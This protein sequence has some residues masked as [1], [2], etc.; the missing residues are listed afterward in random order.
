MS[1][2]RRL[3]RRPPLPVTTIRARLTLVYAAISVLT[4]AGSLAL[5]YLLLRE[6]VASKSRLTVE[7]PDVG[8]LPAGVR[9]IRVTRPEDLA[10]AREADL[11]ELLWLLTSGAVVL[12]AVA[13]LTGWFMAGR[14]LRPVQRITQA[15]RSLSSED[16][17]GRL[18][19]G[20][21]QDEL[22]ELART[23]DGFLDRLQVAVES[24]KRFVAKASHELRTPLAIQR[25]VL[26]VALADPSPEEVARARSDLLE[27]N[28]RSEQLIDA[29]LLLARGEER[30]L[31]TEQVRLDGLVEEVVQEES[32]LAAE[33]GVRLDTRLVPASVRGDRV[34]LRHLV[35]N[36]VRNALAHNHQGGWAMVEVGAD[37]MLRVANTGPVVPEDKVDELFEA[38]S[39]LSGHDDGWADRGTGLGL[40]VVRSIVS[41]HQGQIR[42]CP[43]EGG[44]LVLEVLLPAPEAPT[45]PAGQVRKR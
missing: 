26:Q 41:A 20:G 1:E 19:P 28:R 2:G 3:G 6:R 18:A 21:P 16:L 40:A 37:G 4:T 38:F 45:D 35:G 14:V 32:A 25:A 36:L 42:A 31:R 30:L 9:A 33:R 44:G 15:A 43:R 17:S 27:V 10:A 8:L 22:T 29:L 39:R 23:F 13:V 24:Q 12:L 11:H 7:G 34:L 5:L